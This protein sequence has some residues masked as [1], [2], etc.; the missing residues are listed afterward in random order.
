MEYASINFVQWA[1][2]SWSW[3]ILPRTSPF[4]KKPYFM[5][6]LLPKNEKPMTQVKSEKQLAFFFFTIQ[7]SIIWIQSIIIN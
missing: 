7:V 4:Y 1:Q 2:A 6:Y 3:A 5:Y